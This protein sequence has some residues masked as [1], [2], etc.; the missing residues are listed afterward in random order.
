[1]LAY[2]LII[3]DKMTI[4]NYSASI[5]LSFNFVIPFRCLQNMVITDACFIMDDQYGKIWENDYT[6]DVLRMK[7]FSLKR[8]FTGDIT[9]FEYL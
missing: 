5:K 2:G 3:I 7:M 1:M 6:R 4:P 9:A 8:M